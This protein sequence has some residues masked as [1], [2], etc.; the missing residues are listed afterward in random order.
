LAK[1]KGA[2]TSEAQKQKKAIMDLLAGDIELRSKRE[3]IE[4]FIEEN[5]P[6]IDNADN[7]QLFR[8]RDCDGICPADYFPSV[9]RTL[10]P[11]RDSRF[12]GEY[13]AVSDSYH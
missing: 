7:I 6:H 3:L 5:M 11:T 13:A 9:G 8:N 10:I 12:V 2:K 4:K 1:L